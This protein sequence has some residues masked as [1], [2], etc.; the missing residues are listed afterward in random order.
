MLRSDVERKVLFGAAETERLPAEAYSAEAGAR[1]LRGALRQGAAHPRRRPFGRS[2]TR[3]SHG[4]RSARSSP[5]SPPRRARAFTGSSWPRTFPIRL[6]R[7]GSRRN[8]AS[9]AEA[10][11]VAQQESYDLG[12]IDWT[13][14][15]AS[16]TP[17][18]TLASA[19][20][21]IKQAP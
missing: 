6:A 8:D 18:D 11:V 15:D 7:V 21:A 10:N 9:D 17:D 1:G 2:S 4:P 3:S 5:R 16:G 19:R 12:A 13:E 20:A 14:V